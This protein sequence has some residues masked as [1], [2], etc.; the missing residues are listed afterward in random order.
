[1]TAAEVL[2]AERRIDAKAE[3]VQRELFYAARAFR[4]LSARIE[5]LSA[6]ALPA[7]TPGGNGQTAKRANGQTEG[8][9]E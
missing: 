8:G 7:G 5:R 4:R 2:A 1:M 6:A 3:S 9:A